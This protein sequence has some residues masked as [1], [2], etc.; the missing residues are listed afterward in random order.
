[1]AEIKT[2]FT[3]DDG[4]G[5]YDDVH[6]VVAHDED[7]SSYYAPTKERT[8][9]M[10]VGSS[11]SGSIFKYIPKKTILIVLGVLFGISVLV[12]ILFYAAVMFSKFF[13]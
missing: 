5:F 10:N 11:S 12:K 13:G 1:M 2:V 7:N 4:D 8:V 3:D 9:R 6:H